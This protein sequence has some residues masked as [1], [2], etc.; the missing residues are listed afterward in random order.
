M[1]VCSSY[2]PGIIYLHCNGVLKY[3]F[4]VGKDSQ[5]IIIYHLSSNIYHLPYII[6]IINIITIIIIINNISIISIIIHHHPS[7]II[8]HPSSIIHHP[9]SIIH[10]HHQHQHHHH[11]HHHPS[12]II[13]HPSSIIIII[14]IHHPSSIIHHPSSIIH[15]PSSIIHHPSSSSIIHHHH[16]DPC[17]SHDNH[18]V[19]LFVFWSLVAPWGP[20]AFPLPCRWPEI[21]PP[22]QRNSFLSSENPRMD[23]WNLCKSFEVPHRSIW[24]WG[25]PP[26]WIVDFMENPMKIHDLGVTPVFGNTHFRIPNKFCL[27][28]KPFYKKTSDYHLKP[29]KIIHPPFWH[30]STNRKSGIVKSPTV[31]VNHVTHIPK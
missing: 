25:G 7:S 13:H 24:V 28:R 23:W 4:D 16:H 21:A 5:K 26:K 3:A 27:S 31:G 10:H 9:S 19:S 29:R 15:H 8:H 20:N 12:S 18:D 14:I 2:C 6:N 1:L 22:P 17:H 30:D 11:H